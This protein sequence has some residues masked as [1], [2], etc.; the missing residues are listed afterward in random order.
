MNVCA[1][2]DCL[3]SDNN[4]SIFKF[5][6]CAHKGGGVSTVASQNEGPEFQLEDLKKKKKKKRF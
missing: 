6:F 2:L 4:I 5:C 1:E 3:Y